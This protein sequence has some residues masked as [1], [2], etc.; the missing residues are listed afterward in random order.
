VIW[1]ETA[2][3]TLGG[4]PPDRAPDVELSIPNLPQQA[5]LY[6]LCRDRDPSH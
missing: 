3:T 5:L 2:V 1:S 6:R 4:E